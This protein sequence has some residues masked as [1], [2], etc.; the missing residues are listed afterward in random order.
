MATPDEQIAVIESELGRSLSPTERAQ[1]AVEMG[2]PARSVV[3]DQ[4][5]AAGD[6]GA[7]QA[8][9]MYGGAP[10][11]GDAGAAQAA[12]MYGSG[13]TASAGAAQAMYGGAPV[14]DADLLNPEQGPEAALMS[15]PGDAPM[16]H[17]DAAPLTPEEQA[18]IAA[19]REAMSAKVTPLG[20]SPRRGGGYGGL[21]GEIA[22]AQSD[23]DAA[24]AGKE[25]TARGVQDAITDT[26]DQLTGLGVDQEL[27]SL[28]IDDEFRPKVNEAQDFVDQQLR[29]LQAANKAA[30]DIEIKDSRTT[31]QKILGALAVAFG[32]HAQTL[33]AY[34]A[35][36]KQENLGAKM[37][38]R[39]IE[40]DLQEQRLKL[41]NV[42][43][44]ARAEQ[45]ELSAA[46]KQL[47]SIQ[48]AEAVARAAL[49]DKYAAT[50]EEIKGT[51]QDA[52]QIAEIDNMIFGMR[53][54][55]AQEHKL[56][57]QQKLV[58]AQRAATA[59]AKAQH[60][61]AL[62]Q[63]AM[64]RRDA[65]RQN[66]AGG[67]RVTDSSRWESLHGG[68][69]PEEAKQVQ[70]AAEYVEVNDRLTGILNEMQAL[71]ED[72]GE[73]VPG[74]AAQGRMTSL[75]SQIASIYS[76]KEKLGAM[77]H[78][79]IEILGNVVGDQTTALD[80]FGKEGGKLEA[81]QSRVST[82]TGRWLKSRG[83]AFT[84]R[85]P[86]RDAHRAAMSSRTRPLA[87]G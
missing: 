55:T 61:A 17:P 2:I 39:A 52:Q 30:A 59:R 53:E 20:Q 19:T 49:R 57:A 38:E 66:M 29:E 43:D 69:A 58:A 41:A 77:D 48:E 12:A 47:G 81:I 67:L 42:R 31:G 34:G 50:A 27:E 11:A 18:D 23:I 28:D 65:M 80:L 40:R 8:A 73:G 24:R 46:Y 6:A 13:G 68:S 32:A 15:M 3:L 76:K 26:R 9:A 21:H 54:Q 63:Q 71:R 60:D 82:D 5:P 87:G 72:V 4:V 70:A 37:V 7:S 14:S 16:S 56:T 62:K 75:Q 25:A 85:T 10:A 83:L 44:T 74:T 35:G 51:L 86:H 79:T 1:V 45:T 64:L 78:G 36:V 33:A 84:R 22:A